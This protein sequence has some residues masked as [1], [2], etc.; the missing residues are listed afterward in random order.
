MDSQKNTTEQLACYQCGRVIKTGSQY[1]YVGSLRLLT[2][3]GIDFPKSYHPR[4]YEIAER[5]AVRQLDGG[6][7]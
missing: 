7:A 5:A 3:L 6:A 1:V 2:D 4:C